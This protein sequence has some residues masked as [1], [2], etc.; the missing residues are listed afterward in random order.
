VDCHGFV[1]R[2]ASV[3]RFVRKLVGSSAHEAR[4]VIETAPGE[5]LRWTMAPPA[6]KRPSREREREREPGRRATQER[7]HVRRA[8]EIVDGSVVAGIRPEQIRVRARINLL[9]RF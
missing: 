1:G 6:T 7:M 3:K 5:E 8:E 9:R 2:Y 4:V